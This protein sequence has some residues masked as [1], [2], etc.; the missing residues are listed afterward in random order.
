MIFFAKKI[1]LGEMIV[2]ILIKHPNFSL[3]I[4]FSY[5]K[6]KEYYKIYI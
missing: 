1:Y 2:K 5:S 4:N 3:K 6:E